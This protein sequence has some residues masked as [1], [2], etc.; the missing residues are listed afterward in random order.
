V[1]VTPAYCQKL[2]G[3]ACPV[4]TL[5]ERSF[6]FLLERESNTSILRRFELPVIGSYFPEYERTIRGMLT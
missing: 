3:G 4:E 5:V 2:T 1:T 6:E